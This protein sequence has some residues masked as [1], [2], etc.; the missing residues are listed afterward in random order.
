MCRILW[1]PLHRHTDL[2]FDHS[3]LFSTTEAASSGPLIMYSFKYPCEDSSLIY[4]KKMKKKRGMVFHFAT[5]TMLLLSCSLFL[6]LFSFWF[7]CFD[8]LGRTGAS[9]RSYRQAFHQNC[10]PLSL[11]KERKKKWIMPKGFFL[12]FFAFKLAFIIMSVFHG[13]IFFSVCEGKRFLY[14]AVAC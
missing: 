3:I 7:C 6:Q 4:I 12:D 1:C 2:S 8:S 11:A 14:N 9:L 13:I 5:P 10:L